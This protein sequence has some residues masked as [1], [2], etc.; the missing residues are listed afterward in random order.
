MIFEMIELANHGRFWED[1]TLG[2][3]CIY[4]RGLFY[5][6]LVIADKTDSQQY[7]KQNKNHAIEIDLYCPQGSGTLRQQ[8]SMIYGI[9]W[10]CMILH[11]IA[12]HGMVSHAITCYCM[13]QH[14]IAWY[15][16]VLHGIAWYCRVLQGVAWYST[17]LHG[18]TWYCMV[19]HNIV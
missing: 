16:M 17:V 9:A 2:L 19:K 3:K 10:Y 13:L 1:R 6:V 14:A 7:Q 18:N 5:I 11:C 15:C 12:C 4:I 8:L